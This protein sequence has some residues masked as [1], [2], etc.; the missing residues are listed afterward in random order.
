MVYAD[1]AVMCEEPRI[2][3][4]ARAMSARMAAALGVEEDAVTVKGTSTESMGFT[5][6][7]EG[8]MAIASVLLRETE[9]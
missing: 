7:G 3:P 9:D 8:M 5:G 4:H 2:A 6:R 1:V